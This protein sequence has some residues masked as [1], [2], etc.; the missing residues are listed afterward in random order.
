MHS[1][2]T[3]CTDAGNQ[4][5]ARRTSSAA[6]C[7]LSALALTLTL[8]SGIAN[9]ETVK[10]DASAAPAKASMCVG[11]HEIGGYRTA[12]PTV[13][14]V[15]KIVNQSEAYIVSALKA[16]RSGDRDHGSMTGIAGSLSDQDIADLAA[17]YANGG[18]P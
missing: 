1:G 9:A 7:R 3:P 5:A 2:S 15:P 11:C 12:F 14:R 16:Y 10:G 13:Y 17:Y 4:P 8:A 18:K 6:A